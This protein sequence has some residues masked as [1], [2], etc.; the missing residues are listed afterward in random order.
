[1]SEQIELYMR[2]LRL[3]GLAKTWQTVE[4]QNNEQYVTDL[5]LLELHER[6]VNR[7]ITDDDI[8]RDDAYIIIDKELARVSQDAI[9]AIGEKD[10]LF[11]FPRITKAKSTTRLVLKRPKTETSIRKVWLPWP[12]FFGT[13]SRSRTSSR[14]LW[15]RNTVII[16]WC[17]PWK[18]DGPAR[19]A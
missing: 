11:M 5:L 8:A 13:G 10:I 17:L 1:M 3:G 7:I 2:Q 6:E 4:Y 12:I 18:L 14:N 19:I 15:A 9:Q 16:T